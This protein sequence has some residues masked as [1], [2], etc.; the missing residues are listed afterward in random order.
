MLNVCLPIGDGTGWQVAGANI[1]SELAKL[2]PVTLWADRKE[3]PD[4]FKTLVPIDYDPRFPKKVSGNL[5]HCI[6]GA[7]LLPM[8]QGLYTHGRNIGYCF[9]EDF[10]L[11]GKFRDNADH[12]WEGIVTGSQ[13]CSDGLSDAIGGY[14]HY[15][16]RVH[17]AVQ[18]VD[19]SLFKPGCTSLHR[20]NS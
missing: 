18:G 15:G 16:R 13:W 7:S 14:W 1:V 8:N 4:E 9:I 11:A 17:T 12:Y 6:Q 5:L 19:A 2:T 10:N 3:I 20:I